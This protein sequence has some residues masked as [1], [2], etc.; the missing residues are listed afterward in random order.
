MAFHLSLRVSDLARSVEFYGR[1]FGVAPAK[2][3]PDYA[4]FE[5][6]DPPVVLSLEPAKG[7]DR[8]GL[9]HLGIRLS[10]RSQL[11]DSS[12]AIAAR[13]LTFGHV[14]GVECCYA[15]Q[16]K[17][18][19]NDPDG[20][21]VEIYTVDADLDGAPQA[22]ASF[23]VAG[24]GGEPRDTFDHMLPAPFPLPLSKEPASLAEVNL[25][26]TFN[27]PICAKTAKR[28]VDECLRVL[29]PGGKISTHI[30]V[31]DRAVSGEIPLL[32]EPASHVRR[33]PTQGEMIEL[34]EAAGFVAL[35]LKR[36]S[37]ASVFEFDGAQFREFLLVAH[38][39]AEAGLADGGVGVVYKGPFP[40]IKD[41]QGNEYLRGRRVEISKDAATLLR[42]P[43]YA[44]HFVFVTAG[45]SC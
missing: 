16:S 24:D 5:I 9:D 3:F 7:T 12:S 19:L 36:L 29:L 35:E 33:V 41:E 13:G 44:D 8:K 37:H 32:P 31:A 45:R 1:L 40:S 27:A 11:I 6:A 30:L 22:A 39:P 43:A 21:L 23:N 25:R 42:G 18:Y 15:R 4:K 26:G 34:F 17:I 14:Q 28:I 10:D 20:H 2:Y 38:K